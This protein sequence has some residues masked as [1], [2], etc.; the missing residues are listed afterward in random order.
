MSAEGKAVSPRNVLKG[1]KETLRIGISISVMMCGKHNIYSRRYRKMSSVKTK[2]V[3]NILEQ[4]FPEELI[5][6]IVDCAIQLSQADTLQAA[7]NFFNTSGSA[8]T[9]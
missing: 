6:E 3:E 1:T 8:V 2:V 4:G 9:T 7:C 5:Q